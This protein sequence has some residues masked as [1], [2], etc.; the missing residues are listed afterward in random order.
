MPSTRTG[1]SVKSR[2]RSSGATITAAAPSLISEQS[3]RFSGSATGLPA[4]ACS[5][6]IDF[7]Q[8][9]VRIQRAVGVVLDGHCG[10]VLAR[11]AEIV[12][13]TARDHGE[14]GRKRGAGAD[15]A[16]SSRRPRPGFR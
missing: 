3:Y 10:Q 9:R 15:L 6:V 1:L 5:S 14:Q 4:S 13:V 8:V 11:G 12:H 2:A 7:A 16:R